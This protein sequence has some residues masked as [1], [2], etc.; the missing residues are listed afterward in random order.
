M[1]GVFENTRK[2]KKS[3]TKNVHKDPK[4]IEIDFLKREVNIVQVH[5]LEYE[6]EIKDLRRKN[7]V[8][9]ESVKLLEGRAQNDLAN[10]YRGT[11]PTSSPTA[12]RTC[13]GAEPL[14][15]HCSNRN[16]SP[17]L[18]PTTVE[19][20]LINKLIGFLLDLSAQTLSSKAAPDRPVQNNSSDVS[21]IPTQVITDK[22]TPLLQSGNSSVAN[23]SSPLLNCSANDSVM[24]TG[25]LDEFATGLSQE[26]FNSMLGDSAIKEQN[27][28]N[29]QVLTTQSRLVQD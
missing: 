24:T 27:N 18:P 5:L 14:S 17:P 13:S 23:Q 29:S 10:K 8:L 1:I 3:S 25:T 22:V 28:L 11:I 6:T 7:Q 20:G 26:T 12:P 4:D 16:N 21:Q 15:C 19:P 2:T 9:S